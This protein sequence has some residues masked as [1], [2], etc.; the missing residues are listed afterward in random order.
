MMKNPYV[1]N[2]N[3]HELLALLRQANQS[4]EAVEIQPLDG[5][6]SAFVVGEDEWHAIQETLFLINRGVDQQ[7]RHREADEDVDFDQALRSI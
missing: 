1:P 3:Q 2:R 4:K 7:I 5:E 6:K